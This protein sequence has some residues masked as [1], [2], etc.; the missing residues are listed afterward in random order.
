MTMVDALQPP[1]GD[2]PGAAAAGRR[3]SEARQAQN[4]AATDVARQLKLSLWQVEALEAGR[5]QQL[6]G[7]IFVR[8]FIRNYARLVK[9]DPEELL[10]AAG[11]SLPQRAA[12][13]ETPPSRDIPFPTAH[14]PRW[15]KYAMAAG[16]IFCALA[17]YEFVWNEPEGAPKQAVAVSPVPVPPKPR[18]ES[19]TSSAQA[20][21]EAR[22]A[23]PVIAV[24]TAAAPAGES[25]AAS[26][27]AERVP[28]P[29]E[30][31]VRLNFDRESWVEI[32][33][34]NE[35]VIFSQLNRP[36]TTQEVSGLPPLSVVVGNSQGVRMTFGDQPV[37]LASHTKV[38]VAR[39]I[40]Q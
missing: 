23:Q 8:G 18:S 19:P 31:R 3:L 36:G 1:S 35:R 29:G 39:L 26:A 25:A 11:E 7:P 28:K 14:V 15:P 24:E 32:R 37:D 40:L 12:R 34:R 2:A 13:P 16:A 5:Y 4:L 33:D 6:P 22:S 10:R 20:A 17:V 9:L 38:D 30:K 21:G 27:S